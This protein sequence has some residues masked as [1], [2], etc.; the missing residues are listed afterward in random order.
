MMKIY[1]NSSIP[2]RKSF[3]INYEDFNIFFNDVDGYLYASHSVHVR[4]SELR[5]IDASCIWSD[6][7]YKSR[8]NLEEALFEV[9]LNTI[10]KA[11]VS[12]P[13]YMAIRQY[14]NGFDIKYFVYEAHDHCRR[15]C[16]DS[17]TYDY[18]LNN[19]DTKQSPSRKDKE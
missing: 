9:L 5:L 3:I 4:S 15:E 10:Y 14:K 7:D 8:N 2:N 12:K 19:E 17:Y 18:L 1:V 13:C 16:V 11:S 6:L